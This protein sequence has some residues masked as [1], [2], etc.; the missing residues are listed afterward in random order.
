MNQAINKD[1]SCKVSDIIDVT[2]LMDTKKQFTCRNIPLAK[3]DIECSSKKIFFVSKKSLDEM[4]KSPVEAIFPMVKYCSLPMRKIVRRFALF[5]LA[6]A[7]QCPDRR[8]GKSC[9]KGS[10]Q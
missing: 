8:A 10:Y 1:S 2:T 5:L 7:E 3:C 6:I 9:C 4:G